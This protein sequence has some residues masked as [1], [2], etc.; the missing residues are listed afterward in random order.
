MDALTP[1]TDNFAAQARAVVD[2]LGA[3]P[4]P[5]PKPA[6]ATPYALRKPPAPVR[7]PNPR[8]VDVPGDDDVSPEGPA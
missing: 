4:P 2:A 6:P 3:P 8:P 1:P 5:T 7:P